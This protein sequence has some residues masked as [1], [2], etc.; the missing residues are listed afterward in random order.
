MTRYLV[1]RTLWALFV[2]A[3]VV[4]AVFF[5]VHVA[6][7]PATV[8]LGPRATADAIADFKRQKGLDQPTGAQFG[9]YLGVSPCV[10]LDSPDYHDGEG[11]C[12]LLQGS[13]GTSYTH[14]EDVA[15]VIGHRM[16]R[17]LLLGVMAMVFELIFGIGA[18]ILAALRRNTWTDTGIMVITFAGISVPTFVTGPIALFVVAF[19]LGWFP[20]GGYGVGFWD[21]VYHGLLPSMILAVGGAATYARI[22]RGE[23]VETLRMD[24]VRTAKAKGLGPFPVVVRHA[25]RNALIPIVT[26]LGL[27]LPGLVSGA[28]IT[29]KIFNWPGLGMLTI[30]AINKLD[31]PIIMATVLMFGVLVQLGNLLADVAVAT[32]D[33]R[34]RMGERS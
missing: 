4:T 6:G 10:R 17:T 20:M 33:P 31:V 5:L 25:L 13:L 24:Y 21:H 27:S 18:G 8:A 30:E 11:Y 19:L 22:L 23:L 29:E 7:D 16:P 26:L 32:L 2:L 28:I 12:G 1:K 3:T 9:S 14:R 15:A 34:I